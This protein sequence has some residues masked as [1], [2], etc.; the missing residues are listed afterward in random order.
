MTMPNF[1]A[2]YFWQSPWPLRASRFRAQKND[3]RRDSRADHTFARRCN[4]RGPDGTDLDRAVILRTL[5]GVLNQQTDTGPGGN[6]FEDAGEDFDL[7]RLATLRG[8]TRGT[9]ATTIEVVLQVGFGQ[10]MPGGT[11]STMQPSARPCDSPK[12][13]TRKSCPIVFPA[14]TAPIFSLCWRVVFSLYKYRSAHGRQSAAV[15]SA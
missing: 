13:V 11:P 14:I 9:R 5:I 7:I 10:R 1:A 6:A 15:W 2:R 4:R 3:R 12:V 8:V